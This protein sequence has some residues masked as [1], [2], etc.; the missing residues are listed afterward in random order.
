MN[1]LYVSTPAKSGQVPLPGTTGLSIYYE[2]RGIE[3]EE[4]VLLIMGAFATLR[5]F[6]ELAVSES[7]SPAA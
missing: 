3:H 1:P 5:N 7:I 6:D 2:L 4:K